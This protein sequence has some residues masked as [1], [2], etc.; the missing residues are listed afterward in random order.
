VRGSAQSLGSVCEAGPL[1]ASVVQ[2]GRQEGGVACVWMS[3]AAAAYGRSSARPVRTAEWRCAPAPL[4]SKGF[5][6]STARRLQQL[7]SQGVGESTACRLQ[8]LRAVCPLL[9]RTRSASAAGRG[10][11]ATAEGCAHR[12]GAPVLG[13][14]AAAAGAA[15]SAECT[16]LF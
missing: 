6:E 7:S 12:L 13:L 5:A 2:G 10:W 1:D 3:R 4:S 8:R 15:H 14:R 16:Q 9:L 11:Q